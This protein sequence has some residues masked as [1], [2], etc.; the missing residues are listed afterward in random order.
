MI[1]SHGIEDIGLLAHVFKGRLNNSLKEEVAQI[2]FAFNNFIFMSMG[3]ITQSSK[4]L[5]LPTSQNMTS[6]QV[7]GNICFVGGHIDVFSW[8]H[9]G[10]W[11]C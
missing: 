11:H 3:L 8:F 10:K 5:S 1:D 2:F 9:L 6:S 4:L 7:K